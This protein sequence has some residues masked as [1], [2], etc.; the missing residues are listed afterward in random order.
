VPFANLTYQRNQR[1]KVAENYKKK[2]QKR[3]K[4][5]DNSQAGPAEWI[6]EGSMSCI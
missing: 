2:R 4:K 5:M 6:P 1:L 3:E